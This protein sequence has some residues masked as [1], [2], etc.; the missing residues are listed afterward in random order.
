MINKSSPIPIYFQLEEL[1][2]MA[3]E[4][5]ELIPGQL[6]PSERELAE[7]YDIS[8]MTVRQ[9]INNMVNQGLLVREKGKG[10]FVA[11]KKIEQ[12]LMTLT[13]FS[14]DM[15]SRGLVP[16]TEIREFE[17]ASA[18]MRES[19]ELQIE[20]GEPIYRVSRVRLADAEPMAYEILFLPKSIFPEITEATISRS[21]YK[22]VEK[23]LGMKIERARQT[24]EPALATD[25]ES[26]FLNVKKGSPVLLMRRTSY[27]SN[28][29]PFEYV[30]SVY[31][32][33]RYKFITEMKR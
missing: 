31:R 19:N 25:I 16:G 20:E 5:G 14:E 22:Y 10:T 26:E 24:L 4:N 12:P 13:S 11:D 23:E 1:L 32:G 9:A 28:G 7:K 18:S 21:F 3:V 30:K 27:L 6:I 17:I 15:R 29:R 8:R 2:R 33:D